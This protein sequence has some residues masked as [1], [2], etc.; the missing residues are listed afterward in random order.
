MNEVQYEK[1]L[2]YKLKYYNCILY[3]PQLR[4][5]RPSGVRVGVGGPLPCQLPVYP[6]GAQGHALAH[7]DRDPGQGPRP[8]AATPFPGL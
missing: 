3:S 8:G 4:E 6:G 1:I 2:Y 5:V 7:E